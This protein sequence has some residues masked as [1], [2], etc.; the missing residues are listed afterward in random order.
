MFLQYINVYNA[1]LIMIHR[2]MIT[3]SHI[4]LYRFHTIRQGLIRFLQI[5]YSKNHTIRTRQ[6]YIIREKTIEKNLATLSPNCHWFG[7]PASIPTPLVQV[8]RHLPMVRGFIC[9]FV[10]VAPTL[11]NAGS[12]TP[13]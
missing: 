13:S 4:F 5:I 6:I 11:K 9:P 8:S 7:H 10:I 1:Q 2:T 12:H 3:F